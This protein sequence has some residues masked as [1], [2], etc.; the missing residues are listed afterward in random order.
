VSVYRFHL[1]YIAEQTHWQYQSMSL[2][3]VILRAGKCFNRS[4]V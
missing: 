3:D 1:L 2:A 4:K